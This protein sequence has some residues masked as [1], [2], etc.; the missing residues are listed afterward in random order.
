M[1]RGKSANVECKCRNGAGKMQKWGRNTPDYVGGRYQRACNGDL[2]NALRPCS[3]MRTG[4]AP[5]F[6]SLFECGLSLDCKENSQEAFYLA[7][8][9]WSMERANLGIC[10]SFRIRCL[11]FSM[12][13]YKA[14][15]G[16]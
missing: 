2:E 8:C 11:F 14:R 1:W 16:I 10:E 7:N 12:E 5:S 15:Q 3:K 4:D 6:T 13:R 9:L